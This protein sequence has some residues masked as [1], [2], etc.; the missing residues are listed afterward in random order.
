MSPGCSELFPAV[1]FLALAALL[2][3]TFRGALFAVALFRA[4]FLA[5]AGLGRVTFR[6]ALFAVA[7]FRAA[8]L[9]LAGLGRVTF[10]GVFFLVV[11]FRVAFLALLRRV[12]FLTA[13]SARSLFDS[14]TS[15]E[16]SLANRLERRVMEMTLFSKKCTGCGDEGE[17]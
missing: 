9:A 6:G 16:G 5:L 17:P 7:L 2:L 12:F 8:F 4:A 10:R 14:V 11:L 1:P 15:G 13:I 3:V